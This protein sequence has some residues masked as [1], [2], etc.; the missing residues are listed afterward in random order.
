MMVA[1]GS[2][3]VAACSG[4][5]VTAGDASDDAM[6]VGSSGGS[7]GGSSVG[8]SSG[9]PCCINMVTDP[10]L[11]NPSSCVPEAG[12]DGPTGDASV[13][14]SATDAPADAPTDVVYNPFCCNL[15][16][17]PCCQYLHCGGALTTTCSSELACQADGGTWEIGGSTCSFSTDGGGGG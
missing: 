5:Q 4:S 11:L 15:V 10:C 6:T 8:T 9:A 13:D 3:V 16:A 1:G 7:S 12:P 2:V 14:A 17:D